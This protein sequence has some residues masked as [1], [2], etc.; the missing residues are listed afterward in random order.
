MPNRAISAGG[1][2]RKRGT[3]IY[4][5]FC[6]FKIVFRQREKTV[7]IIADDEDNGNLKRCDCVQFKLQTL[8]LH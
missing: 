4:R 7:D 5:P 3:L 8:A 6:V 1:N 2:Q